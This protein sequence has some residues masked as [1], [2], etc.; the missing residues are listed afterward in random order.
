MAPQLQTIKLRRLRKG[1][2]KKRWIWP[3]FVWPFVCIGVAGQ[4]NCICIIILMLQLKIYEGWIMVEQ[5]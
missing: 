1:R 2:K 5:S 4:I 3:C